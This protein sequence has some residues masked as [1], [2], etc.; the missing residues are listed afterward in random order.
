MGVKN[1]GVYG[2]G[3]LDLSWSVIIMASSAFLGA[4]IGATVRPLFDHLVQRWQQKSAWRRQ[5]LEQQLNE[6]Y[7]PL[8]EKMVIMPRQDPTHYFIDW[9]E[10]EF[11][12]WLTDA[13]DIIIPK[14]HL[15]PD[16][17]LSKIHGWRETVALGPEFDV[18]AETDTRFLYSHIDGYFHF[19]RKELGIS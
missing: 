17:I 7:R 18:S 10:D 5:A 11:K 13:L 19:L 2:M 14:L 8:Y 9:E 12:K 1:K 16:E 3:N 6:L 4:V 15:V